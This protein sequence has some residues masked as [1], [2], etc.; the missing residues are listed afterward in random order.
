MERIV[1]GLERRL[2]NL[3][4]E[5]MQP[6]VDARLKKIDPD[7]VLYDSYFPEPGNGFKTVEFSHYL[8]EIP[9]SAV[10]TPGLSWYSERFQKRLR[11]F[12]LQNPD[13]RNRVFRIY[14]NPNLAP[15]LTYTVLLYQAWQL[16]NIFSAQPTGIAFTLNPGGGFSLTSA[17][18]RDKIL[19]MTHSRKFKHI[20]ATQRCTVDYLN[21][22]GLT[23]GEHF[24]FIYGSLNFE[25][26]IQFHERHWHGENQRPL[27]IGFAGYKYMTGG[28]DK[29][30]D[31][32]C[33]VAD[34]AHRAGHDW[35]FSCWGTFSATDAPD[36]SATSRRVSFH[37]KVSHQELSNA[38]RAVD[39]FISPNRANQLLPGAFDG[40][41][42]GTAIQAGKAGAAL[43]IT[44]PM[45]L[46]AGRFS[47]NQDLILATSDP[48]PD[49]AEIYQHILSLH[50]NPESISRMGMRGAN[51]LARYFSRTAQL[52]PRERILRTLI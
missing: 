36:P 8:R 27:H 25:S 50:S 16:W 37:G 45:N 7:L 43:I 46:N 4:G 42:L 20:F 6:A 34:I 12:E 13:M 49:A 23:E 47:N 51:T 2:H 31:I 18:S 40:F 41:P 17:D 26:P 11:D 1:A 52:T 28:I 44:D 10:I 9:H 24:T 39:I 32:F 38:M 30:F 5:L 29:G 14:K 35:K 3:R 33:Q 15:K 22:L 21:E 48:D 19:R